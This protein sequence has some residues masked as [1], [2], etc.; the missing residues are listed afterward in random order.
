MMKIEVFFD[1]DWDTM[2]VIKDPFEVPRDKKGKKLRPRHWTEEQISQSKANSKVISILID[3]L[4][5]NVM[6]C[7]GEYEN[8]HDLWSKIKKVQ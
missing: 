7:V 8:A 3:M 4:P 5:S 2:M 1:T 6:R